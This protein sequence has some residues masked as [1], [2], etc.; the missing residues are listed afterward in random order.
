MTQMLQDIDGVLFD[1]DDTLLC[2]SL[3]YQRAVIKLISDLDEAES[4]KAEIYRELAIEPRSIDP[5][6]LENYL[7]DKGYP[8]KT[9]NNIKGNYI[10]RMKN[11]PL[12]PGVVQMFEALQSLGVV[13]GIVSN[14]D[15]II[16]E[17]KIQS[18][19][20]G[21]FFLNIY[22]SRTKEERKPSSTM[23]EKALDDFDLN[24][25]KVAFVGDKLVEDIAPARA[26][27]MRGIQVFQGRFAYSEDL[28]KLPEKIKTKAIP[29]FLVNTVTEIAQDRK[30]F[31]GKR[32]SR[33]R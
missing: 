28:S 27:G 16:Q 23:F 30:G 18:R 4:T 17:L 2:T 1:L 29:D 9:I 6:E 10:K 32:R 24:P 15:P 5:K 7:S 22:I 25:Q 31:Q 11:A 3:T 21:R 20:I 14:G 33:T 8:E 13:L 12:F 26:L 19:D